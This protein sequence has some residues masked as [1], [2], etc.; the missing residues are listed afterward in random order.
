M[1]LLLNLIWLAMVLASAAKFA[2]WS[3]TASRG[4]ARVVAVATICI[5]ALLFPIIS[6]T[7]DLHLKKAVVEEARSIALVAT[8]VIAVFELVVLATVPVT[9]VAVPSSPA[10]ARTADRGPP[11]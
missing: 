3:R 1:E 5:L 8:R 4:R 6:I 10:A 2:V 7:D 9:T 11:V